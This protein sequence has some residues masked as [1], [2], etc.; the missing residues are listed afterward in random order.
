MKNKDKAGLKQSY[1]IGVSSCIN[2]AP[3]VNRFY[4]P[5]DIP[6]YCSPTRNVE[7]VYLTL[8]FPRTPPTSYKPFTTIIKI[9]EHEVGRIVNEVPKGYYVFEVD[10]SYLNYADV[11]VAEN[12]ITLDVEGMNR[13]YYVPLQGYEIDILFKKAQKA[14]CAGSQDEANQVIAS[15][16]RALKHD[17]DFVICSADI[18]F[19]NSKP[20]ENDEVNITAKIHN[21]GSSGSDVVVSIFID[22]VEVDSIWI[23]YMAPF[24]TYTI[25][26]TWIAERGDHNVK[27]V[28]NSDRDVEESDYTNNEASKTISVIAQ[29]TEP[30]IISNLKPSDGAV[31]TINRPLISADLADPGSGINTTAVRIFV[32]GID[33]TSNAT[34]ISS[35]VWYIPDFLEDGAH[36]I[37]VY[38]EDNRGNN[39]TCNWS[40]TV[41]TENRPPIPRFSF[42]P[43]PIV[44]NQ[45]VEFNASL[46]YDPDGLIVS[47]EWDFGDGN[48]TNT[49][50]ETINHSYSKAGSYDVTLTV[51][52][53]EGATNSTSKEITVYPAA[54]FDTGSPEN[55]YP[56]IAGMHNGTITPNKTIIAT[57]L[58][59]YA[60]EGTGGHTE[61]ARIWNETWSATASW[62]GYAEDWHNI[63]FDKEVVLIANKTYNFT[64]I[65]GSYPQIYHTNALL[66]ENGWINCTEFIDANGEIHYNW[67]PAIKLW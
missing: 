50:E 66:T 41:R 39:K 42:S 14:V 20:S 33:V 1:D 6:Q 45:T 49:T 32:D 22:D 4:M 46:S 25:E 7:K 11:G 24:S 43:C 52:D 13:G 16:I 44:V 15:N 23:P 48:V 19:S 31:V 55:P 30:P 56:S 35:R 54:I 29:D 63:T 8:Y 64:I 59:T 38:A 57:K 9:N 34:V 5:S 65:T 17:V 47:Y 10:P 40:F 2:H 26:T 61:Y 28:V 67:I 37:T 21:L 3:L 62:K 53:D 27:I 18:G 58:Y 12:T 60:C 36:T 51:T